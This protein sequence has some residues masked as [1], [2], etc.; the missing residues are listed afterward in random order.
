MVSRFY[1]SVFDLIVNFYN[2]YIL[3]AILIVVRSRDWNSKNFEKKLKLE[4][5]MGLEK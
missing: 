5:V 2:D 4:K 1:N 3:I